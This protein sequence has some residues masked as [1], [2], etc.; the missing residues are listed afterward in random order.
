MQKKIFICGATGFL[1]EHLSEYLLK[2]Y[3][4]TLHGYKIKTKINSDFTKNK[5]VFKILNKFKPNII[6]NLIC[7]SNVEKCEQNFKMAYTLNTL[8]VKNI[9]EWAIKNKARLIQISTDHVY[10]NKKF[11]SENVIQLENIYA[12]TKFLGELEALKAKGLVIRTNF[13][14][15]PKK[16]KRGLVHWLFES[17]KKN[18][19]IEMVKDIYFNPVHITTLCKIIEKFFVKKYSGIV[20]VG[21]K[22]GMSKKNFIL[23]VIN[24]KNLKFRNFSFVNYNQ[25]R[26]YKCSRPRYMLMNTNK[27]KKILKVNIPKLEDEIKKI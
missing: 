17:C 13:F 1:G 21:S 27:L 3:S 16:I 19:R 22:N 15:A 10:N 18:M 14:A 20:N 7:F 5:E 25:L 2:K 12:A 24:Y 8:V 11:S 6:I 9:S 23:K 26:N 4:L